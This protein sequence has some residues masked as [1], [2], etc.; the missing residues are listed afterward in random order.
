MKVTKEMVLA[1][2]RCT[3]M[4]VS[5]SDEEVIVIHVVPKDYEQPVFCFNCSGHAWYPKSQDSY[6]SY[7]DSEMMLGQMQFYDRQEAAELLEQM[8]A[9]D[10]PCVGFDE[11]P[12]KE[13][14]ARNENEFL[15]RLGA[16]ARRC[17]ETRDLF[18]YHRL[19]ELFFDGIKENVMIEVPCELDFENQSGGPA[20][21]EY[22]DGSETLVILTSLPKEDG[23]ITLPITLRALVQELDEKDSYDGILINPDA[24]DLFLPKALLKSA[25]AAG[26]QMAVDAIE[27]EAAAMA[28]RSEKEIVTKRPISPEEFEAIQDRVRAFEQNPD[29]FLKIMLL[30]EQ[31]LC[32]LQVLRAESGRHLSIGFHMEQFGWD[33]PL[34]LGKAL[35]TEK[36]LEIMH[37]ILVENK[38]TDRIKEIQH[39]VNMGNG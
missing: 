4:Q 8:N 36:V 27:E 32:F 29:D 22:E 31:E 18:D 13:K 10:C 6:W 33:K 24:E 16:A 37:K 9:F 26:Y 5:P 25:L 11:E 12:K 2:E 28:G 38:S 17:D 20:A 14:A 39:F 19:L 1:A 15:A 3:G 30:N 34:I 35:E 7:W 21:I 23:G